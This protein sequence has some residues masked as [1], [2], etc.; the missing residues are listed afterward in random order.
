[1]PSAPG[2]ITTRR[3]VLRAAAAVGSSVALAPVALPGLAAAAEA[4]GPAGSATRPALLRAKISAGSCRQVKVRVNGRVRTTTVCKPKKKNKKNKGTKTP[5]AGG[6][7]KAP[8]TGSKPTTPA[9]PTPTP[10]PTPAPLPAGSL[11]SAADRHLVSR[12]SYGVDRAQADQVL[13]AGGGAAWFEAQLTTPGSSDPATDGLSG[14]WPSL[15]RTPQDLWTRTSTGVE[16]SWL[17]MADYQRYLLLRRLRSTRP[18]LDLMAEF[19]ENHFNVP[20][21]ADAVF[22]YRVSYGQALRE[23]ALGTF[24]DILQTAITHPAMLMYLSA[25][26]STKARPNENLGRELLELHTVGRGTYTE[27]DVKASA[28]ILTGYRVA[29]W[30]TWVAS[31]QPGDHWTGPLTVMGFSDAN[32]SP[33]GRAT[34]T[35]YLRYLARHPATAQRI[36]RKLATKFV[37]DSPSQALVE[38]LAAVYLANDTA[39]APVLR[40][41]VASPE[42]A[43]AVA[44]KVRDPAEDVVATYKALGIQVAAPVSAPGARSGN[45]AEM[46]ILWQ[47]E[48]LGQAPHNWPRPDGAPT[49]NASWSSTSRILASLELHF[50]LSGQWWP[51][52]GVTYRSA[53]QWLPAPSVTFADL[54]EHLSR[55][56]LHLPTPPG[57]L[58]AA[59]QAAGTP[60][61]AVITIDHPVV[62][63]KFAR[64]L[65]T[66]LDCPLH[67]KR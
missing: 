36:A 38:Q 34:A 33:D 30:T 41:L 4:V 57:L 27:D 65:T 10:T 55:E 52:Q 63:W 1:M 32:A 9:R 28:R 49:D 47:C 3:S 13:L 62:R 14:W 29:M 20:V 26:V 7:P 24:E 35:A 54:V 58:T 15:Q 8:V 23:R 53:A 39:I 42:F 66:V 40:A 6:T 60:P 22:T 31:Y 5:T 11:L 21:M 2:S 18:V 12:F 45:S 16:G 50:T 67:L 51:S 43:A 61:T 25:A 48:G 44:S 17:V 37:S 56:M 46:A 19:W 64:L 59:S